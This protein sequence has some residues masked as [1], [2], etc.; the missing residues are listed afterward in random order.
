MLIYLYHL[1]KYWSAVLDSK[2]IRNLR[3]FLVGY[4]GENSLVSVQSYFLPWKS[5]MFLLDCFLLL[6]SYHCLSFSFCWTHL[7]KCFYTAVTSY[8]CETTKHRDAILGKNPLLKTSILNS[9]FV[10]FS[11]YPG[12][13]WSENRGLI[14]TK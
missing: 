3:P 4:I 14:F 2:L 5:F 11:R 9:K 1:L 13:S 7:L 10:D 6:R 12:Q 8:I